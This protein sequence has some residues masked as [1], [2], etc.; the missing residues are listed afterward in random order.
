E[1]PPYNGFGSLEDSLASTKS[2]LPK[3]PRADFAKQVD[4]ATKML[5]Y[6][7]RL[8][9]SRSEDACRRF[10]LSYRLCDDMIS[11]YETP[12][13]NS[14]FPGGTFLRRA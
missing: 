9:S 4:Y 3:P 13:R 11:I 12:M 8:D 6:E 1:I 2:F 10:I 7:A 14:G 5:R